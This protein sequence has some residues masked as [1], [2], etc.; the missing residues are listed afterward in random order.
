MKNIK[1]L[2]LKR[3]APFIVFFLSTPAVM[4]AGEAN[5]NIPSKSSGIISIPNPLGVNSFSELINR[6]IDFLIFIGAPVVTVMIL[7]AAFKIMSA[8][9]DENKLIEG[10]KTIQW[11]ALGYALLLISKG[12]VLIINSILGV[13]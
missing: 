10:K 5:V 7:I 6:I 2:V 11:A 9:D 4:A 12:V 8:G 13:S 1:N 3:T